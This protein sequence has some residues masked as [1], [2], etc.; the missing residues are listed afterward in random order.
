MSSNAA[1][2][3]IRVMTSKIRVFRIWRCTHSLREKLTGGNR[4]VAVRPMSNGPRASVFQR[5]RDPGGGQSPFFAA[6]EPEF[7]CSESAS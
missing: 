5:A 7:G 2:E 1:C 6:P 3:I 4:F